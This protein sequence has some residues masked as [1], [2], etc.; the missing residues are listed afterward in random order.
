MKENPTDWSSGQS[1]LPAK[2]LRHRI[3]NEGNQYD[4]SFKTDSRLLPAKRVRIQINILLFPRVSWTAIGELAKPC[5]GSKNL[6]R[7]LPEETRNNWADTTEKVSASTTSNLPPPPKK[8]FFEYLRA[9]FTFA[10]SLTGDSGVNDLLIS[11]Q[12]GGGGMDR[13][14]RS[15]T[16]ILT[17]TFL[18][19]MAAFEVHFLFR[20]MS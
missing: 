10:K 13:A 15:V 2:L 14:F 18:A 9:L 4:K 16:N 12:S 5:L 19:R 7:L 8:N 17:Q 6:W 1:V 20:S 3:S 11:N